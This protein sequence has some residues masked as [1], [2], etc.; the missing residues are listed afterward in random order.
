VIGAAEARDFLAPRPV[1]ILPGVG[2]AFAEVLE[3]EG[4]RRI[5]DLAAADP[6]RLADRHGAHGLRLHQLAQGLDARPVNPAEARKSLSSETTFDEDLRRRGDLED[7]LWPLCEK[8]ASRA[9]LE[10]I[11]GRVVTLKLKT[12][13]FRTLTR[14]RTLPSPTQTAHTLFAVGRELLAAGADGGAFRLVGIGISELVPGGQAGG[15]LFAGDESRRLS[16]ER[17]IDA[18]RGRF[19][20]AAVVSGRALKPGRGRNTPESPPKERGS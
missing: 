4:F 20:P 18:L 6:R 13:D 10:A 7:A 9:R 15:D 3:R 8:V 11:A 5:G 12:A 17:A 1:S 2:P 16:G 19:G 14:R